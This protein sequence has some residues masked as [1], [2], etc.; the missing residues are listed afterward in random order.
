MA[1]KTLLGI[2]LVAFLA[3]WGC[4][5]PPP[6][7]QPRLLPTPSPSPLHMEPWPRPTPLA[8]PSPTATAAATAA[9]V[10]VTATPPLPTP[11]GATL[12]PCVPQNTSLKP[13]NLTWQAIQQGALLQLLNQGVPLPNLDRALQYAGVGGYPQAVLS[14]DLNGDHK[15]DAVISLV[16]PHSKAHPP[17]GMLLIYLCQQGHFAQPYAFQEPATD[18]AWGVP[19]VHFAQDLNADGRTEL[20]VSSAHC[21]PTG[22]VCEERYAILGWR[23][24][25]LRDL[26]RDADQPFPSPVSFV[27]DPDGDGICDFIIETGDGQRLV[28]H[29]QNGVWKR[30]P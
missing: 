27:E 20:V 16:D 29:Y 28:W 14:V 7:V 3:L 19:I 9:P 21:D 22:T 8:L 6:S 10:A 24:G 18:R 11:T 25:G 23:D 13:Q 12:Q 26:L 17:Q 30:Q 5:A 1:K 4:L 2:L 15:E